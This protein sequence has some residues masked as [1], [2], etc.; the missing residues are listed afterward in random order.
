MAWVRRSSLAVVVCAAVATTTSCAGMSGFG[1]PGASCPGLSAADP[2]SLEYSANAQAN[3]KIKTF[4]KASRD[5]MDASVRL[6]A[7]TA[8]ACSAIARDL[9]A[10]PAEIAPRD[11]E[12][13]SRAKAACGAASARIDAILRMGVSFRIQVQPPQCQADFQAKARCDASCDVSID[14]GQIVA[15]CEPA[16]LSGFCQGRCEGRCDGRCQGQCQGQCSAVDANGQCNGTCSGSCSGGCDATCHARCEGQWQAPQCEGMVRPPSADAECNASCN[17][18]ANL[19]A[20][21]TPAVVTVQTNA[22]HEAAMRLVASLQAHLPWLLKAELGLG[23]RILQ[24]AKVVVDVG[25]QLPKIVG[26]AGLTGLACVAASASASV[27][28]SARINVSVQASASVS[29]KAS[30]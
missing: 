10:P 27:K 16:K 9:G 17:A 7:L 3:A 6:E 30:G 11:D 5:L 24:D 26:N 15:Q 25:A 22:N 1:V 19:R 21:C 28:A 8:D 13:G 23:R 14:P 29:A 20:E 18:S 2:L 4:V 12:P